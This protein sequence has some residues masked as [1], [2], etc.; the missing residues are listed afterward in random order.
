VTHLYL[1]DSLIDMTADETTQ[2]GAGFTRSDQLG[3]VF[4]ALSQ[5]MRQCLICERVFTRRA[6]S[7]HAKVA[8][9]PVS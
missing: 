9:H 5:D 2:R 4:V 7:E 6:A 8:C 1:R 3:K